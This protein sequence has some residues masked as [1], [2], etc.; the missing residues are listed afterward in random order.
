MFSLQCSWYFC[1]FKRCTV[2]CNGFDPVSITF[3]LYIQ[4]GIA[5]T[6]I[7]QYMLSLHCLGDKRLEFK[8][9]SLKINS[10]KNLINQA[11]IASQAP[12]HIVRVYLRSG[13]VAIIRNKIFFIG[14][15][16]SRGTINCGHTLH[17]GFFITGFG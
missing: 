12:K 4:N 5:V 6:E 2:K 15:E 9:I 11:D 1:I 8:T 14:K 13:K 16:Q 7:G 10:E 17:K 3:Q